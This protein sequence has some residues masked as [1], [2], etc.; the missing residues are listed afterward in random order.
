MPLGSGRSLRNDDGVHDWR[1]AARDDSRRI[2][3]A[4]NMLAMPISTWKF[5]AYPVSTDTAVC[6][7]PKGMS[8]VHSVAGRVSKLSIQLVNGQLHVYGY[9]HDM[10][11]EQEEGAA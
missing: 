4:G 3:I 1:C 9:V 7:S 6:C 11:R 2:W 8:R 10:R 5:A